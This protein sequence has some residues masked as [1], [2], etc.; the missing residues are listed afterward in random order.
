MKTG[1]VETEGEEG[2]GRNER[3]RQRR[4][5]RR[6]REVR[7]GSKKMGGEGKMRKQRRKCEL[8]L[9]KEQEEAGGD[10]EEGRS[11]VCYQSMKCV[12]HQCDWDC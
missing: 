12:E 11:A 1:R 4:G 8:D 7:R 9:L 10:G 6:E 2:S 3:K 5:E